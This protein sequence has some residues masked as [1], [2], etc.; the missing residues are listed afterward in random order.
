MGLSERI[1]N[2]V[3]ESLTSRCGFGRLESAV[4]TEDWELLTE[5]IRQLRATRHVRRNGHTGLTA[6]GLARALRAEGHHISS[7]TVQSHAYEH[8]RCGF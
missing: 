4:S 1:E 5:T 3:N 6:A 2:V 7:D 8:C